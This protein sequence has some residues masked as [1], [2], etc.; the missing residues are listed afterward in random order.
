LTYTGNQAFG[1]WVAVITT[2]S[3]SVGAHV[4]AERYEQLTV[5]YRATADRL[6]GILG[7]WKAGHGTLGQ[8]VEQV[9]SAL[10]QEN[11]A[12]IAGAD[13]LLKDLVPPPQAPSAA[14]A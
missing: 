9:E 8:L 10:L 1:A 2:I 11:Q 12:W 7:R 5:S 6:T 14:Q 3:G 4:L 13:D